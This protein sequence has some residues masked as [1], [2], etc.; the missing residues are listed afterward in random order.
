VVTVILALGVDMLN[1]YSRVNFLLLDGLRIL[2]FVS[3]FKGIILVGLLKKSKTAYVIALTE[4]ALAISYFLFEMRSPVLLASNIVMLVIFAI[5]W[6]TFDVYHPTFNIERRLLIILSSFVGLLYLQ[7][8]GFRLLKSSFNQYFGFSDL[9]TSYTEIILDPRTLFS[10]EHIRPNNLGGWW[11]F[12]TVLFAGALFLI[13]ALALLIVPKLSSTRYDLT[14]NAHVDPQ[15]LIQDTDTLALYKLAQNTDIFYYNQITIYYK[16]LLKSCIVLGDPV[17]YVDTNS[18]DIEA[19][20]KAF[21]SYVHKKGKIVAYFQTTPRYYKHIL[22]VKL[23]AIPFAQEAI[24][25]QPINLKLPEHKSL[26]NSLNRVQRDQLQINIKTFATLNKHDYEAFEQLKHEWRQTQGYQQMHFTSGYDAFQKELPGYMVLV[27]SAT[28]V[29]AIL[30]FVPF[31]VSTGEQG[32]VLDSMLRRSQTKSGIIEAALLTAV[33]YFFKHDC[34]KV[35]L[36][37]APNL[38]L[39]HPVIQN[40]GQ[41]LDL[42]YTHTGLR[43]FKQKFDPQWEQRY[44]CMDGYQSLPVIYTDL[45]KLLFRQ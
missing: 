11:F 41:L 6:R 24:L 5:N 18:T 20:L 3:I 39:Q 28:T 12:Y 27:Q 17:G 9:I 10:Y 2:G 21:S 14:W 7:K 22:K 42:K 45:Q 31:T 34:V 29:V 37:V 26:R 30:T 40:I 8:I 32:L 36:G 16:E 33:D 25:T 13:T 38:G 15:D 35:S 43:N 4:I 19:A 44:L 23:I 1:E